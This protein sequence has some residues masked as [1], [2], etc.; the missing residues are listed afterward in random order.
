MT[1]NEKDYW[2]NV[3]EDMMFIDILTEPVYKAMKYRF[4]RPNLYRFCA[5]ELFINNETLVY[6]RY[7]RR[8]RQYL[9]L[10]N[11]GIAQ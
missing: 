7:N 5:E 2:D 11:A 1:E 4:P 9:K 3:N 10:I 6:Q 8:I